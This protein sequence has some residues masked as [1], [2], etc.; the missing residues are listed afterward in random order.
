MNNLK[1]LI[2][3]VGVMIALGFISFT[4]LF[5]LTVNQ[6]DDAATKVEIRILQSHYLELSKRLR[7][8]TEDNTWWTAAY[9][10]IAVNFN[11]AW[12]R[13]NISDDREVAEGKF[14]FGTDDQILYTDMTGRLPTP[15]TFLD[16]GLE[17]LLTSLTLSETNALNSIAIYQ[18]FDGR[19][20]NIGIGL[21]QESFLDGRREQ[22]DP[23]RAPALVL[24]D[25]VT[26][27]EITATGITLNLNRFHLSNAFNND[28]TVVKVD[29]S[30]YDTVIGNGEPLY[31]T[32]KSKTLAS[33]I[34]AKLSFPTL[35]IILVLCATFIWFYR[36][37]TAMVN[38]L[39]EANRAKSDFLANMSHEIRTPLNAIMGFTEMVRQETF[40]KVEGDKNKEYLNIV[41]S[42][43]HHLLTLINEILDL[44]K[45]EAGEMEVV[46]EKFDI[47]DEVGASID[48]LKRLASEKGI[49]IHKNLTETTIE[50]DK[51]L[52]VQSIINI[53][54]NAIKFTPPDGNI[55]VKSHYV[56][57]FVVIDIKDDGLGMTPEELQTALVHFGQVQSGYARSNTGTGLGLTLVTKFME[58]LDGRMEI[59]TEKGLGT[60]VSLFFPMK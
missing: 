43:S 52:F 9:E 44:S 27:E 48:T 6:S 4:L 58:L 35:L 26:E 10:N 39:N 55:H 19:L 5:I 17:E 38:D 24:I 29:D 45:V 7:A 14:I 13:D 18:Y 32:W 33:D 50:C 49:K 3:P 42:S 37:A 12:I 31:F 23:K 16:K 60:T 15:N 21:V 41:Q 47:V 36:N 22:F 59:T 28:D 57:N 20:F 8:V 54:S 40:G 30:F 2:I 34:I 56:D 25:E 11:E 46:L 51:K 1:S 53:L